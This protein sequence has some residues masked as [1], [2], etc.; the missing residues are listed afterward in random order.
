MD[1][2]SLKISVENLSVEAGDGFLYPLTKRFFYLYAY[3][4]FVKTEAGQKAGFVDRENIRHLPFWEKNSFASIGKQIRRHIVEMGQLGRNVIEALQRIKGPFG[5]NVDPTKITFD[6]DRESIRRFLGL[7]RLAVFYSEKDE[8]HLYGFVE[9][10]IQGDIFFNEG[11]LKKSLESFRR[12]LN[13][14]MTPNQKITVLQRIGRSLERQG[15][16][17]EAL[18]TYESAETIIKKDSVIDYY[19]LAS[20]YN[21]LA[22]LHYREGNFELSEKTYFKAFDL[23]RGKTHNLLLGRIYDGL[24]VIYEATGRYKE[25]L[26]FFKNSLSLECLE[27]DFYGISAAYFNIGNIYKRMADHLVK[28]SKI[29]VKEISKEANDLY[30]QAISWGM[31]CINLTDRTGVGDE[32]SQ[33]RI[34]VSYCYYR[35]KKFKKAMA[36]AKD[37]EEMASTAGSKRDLALSYDLM[38]KILRAMGGDNET[39]ANEYLQK[40]LEY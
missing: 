39:K 7:D 27:S 19:G 1:R 20:L 28:D 34:L 37:A 22:W 26:G 29:P 3:L 14:S 12:A 23:I 5:L 35:L 31:K 6:A 2:S 40:S 38:G 32:T 24:A 15:D 18:M 33:D 25:A 17:K 13:Q 11:L 10:I 9:E 21:N 30:L 8:S 36:Y 16:Y 4:A